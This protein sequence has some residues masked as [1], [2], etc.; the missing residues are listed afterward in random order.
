MLR[1]NPG[2]NQGIRYLL[3][4]CLLEMGSDEALGKLLDQYEDDATAIWLYTRA[5]WAFRRLGAGPEANASLRTALKQNRFVPQYLLGMKKLPR[6]LP[7]YIGFGD[8]D[9][10]VAYVAEAGAGWWKTPGAM[11]WLAATLSSKSN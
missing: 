5:L 7:E 9:E 10:A 11:E 4:A 6:H 1:L 2:D 3:A 8:E